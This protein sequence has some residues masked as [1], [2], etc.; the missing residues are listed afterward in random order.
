MN[1]KYLGDGQEHVVEWSFQTI[2]LP[3]FEDAQMSAHTGIVPDSE[4]GE[5]FYL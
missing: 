1:I 2:T 3:Q 5:T 4:S